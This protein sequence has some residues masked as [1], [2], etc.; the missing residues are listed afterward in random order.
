MKT[1]QNSNY[2]LNYR[3]QIKARNR[4]PKLRTC[5]IC[6]RS[7]DDVERYPVHFKP[8]GLPKEVCPECERKEQ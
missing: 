6:K 1:Y 5:P 4:K 7:F 3:S 8:Y 2:G